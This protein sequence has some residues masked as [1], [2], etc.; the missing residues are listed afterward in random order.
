MKTSKTFEKIMAPT[1]SHVRRLWRQR[2]R[3]ASRRVTFIGAGFA[4]SRA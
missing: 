2:L 3:Q 4:S 1:V